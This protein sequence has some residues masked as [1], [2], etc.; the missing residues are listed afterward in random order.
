MGGGGE[1]LVSPCPRCP[2]QAGSFR[3]KL[4]TRGPR[5][6][7]GFH[8][9]LFPLVINMGFPDNIGGL[10]SNEAGVPMA[11]GQ[12]WLYRTPNAVTKEISPAVSM[13]P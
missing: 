10:G 6:L 9:N 12:T 13:S 4:S 7:A 8:G 2:L 3:P 1:L 11:L 5:I